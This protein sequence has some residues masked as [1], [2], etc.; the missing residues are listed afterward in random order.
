VLEGIN[1]KVHLSCLSLEIIPEIPEYNRVKSIFF[2][3]FIVSDMLFLLLPIY[4]LRL[5]FQLGDELRNQ[6][7]ANI[8]VY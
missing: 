1:S 3:E 8:P 7:F 6:L 2:E 4:E 5:F